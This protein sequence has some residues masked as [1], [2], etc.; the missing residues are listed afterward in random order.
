MKEI[1]AN[2]S[3]VSFYNRLIIGR[4]E[5]SGTA[6]DGHESAND[7]VG[8]DDDDDE[9]MDMERVISEANDNGCEFYL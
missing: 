5:T 4:H 2:V 7:N 1:D 6:S 9:N 8:D 3:F